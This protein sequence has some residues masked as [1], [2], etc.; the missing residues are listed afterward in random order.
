MSALPWSWFNFF[1][2]FCSCMC[3]SVFEHAPVLTSKIS[4]AALS[5]LSE[6]PW[7]HWYSP[8]CPAQYNFWTQAP[9]ARGP[10]QGSRPNRYSWKI[11]DPFRLTEIQ[12]FSSSDYRGRVRKSRSHLI[13][14][15]ERYPVP[16]AQLS[17]NQPK[18]E[19]SE[20]KC[21]YPTWTTTRVACLLLLKGCLQEAGLGLLLVEYLPEQMKALSF[22]TSPSLTQLLLGSHSLAISKSNNLCSMRNKQAAEP[23][24]CTRKPSW[25]TE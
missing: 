14:F 25:E 10:Q 20:G 2:H 23:H 21:I 8:G 3:M 15:A 7:K 9:G 22:L 18:W 1:F 11:L 13:L 6:A 19:V 24:A 12:N 4:T 17:P 5:W 16:E